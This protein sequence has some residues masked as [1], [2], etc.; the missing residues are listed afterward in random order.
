VAA[1]TV[2]AGTVA[3]TDV[4][5]CP[6]TATIGAARCT[7]VVAVKATYSVTA[8]SD[9]VAKAGRRIE[10]GGGTR[11]AIQASYLSHLLPAGFLSIPF[12]FLKSLRIKS[13]R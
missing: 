1:T 9:E 2:A 11:T 10:A 13:V 7:V 12:S 5:T 8:A 6:I 4:V 3:A